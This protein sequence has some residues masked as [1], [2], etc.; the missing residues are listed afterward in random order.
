VESPKPLNIKTYLLK[1]LPMGLITLVLCILSLMKGSVDISIGDLFNS[2]F[3]SDTDPL[4]SKILFEIRLPRVILAV[5]VGGGLGVAGVVFQAVLMNPLAE[6]YILGISSGGAFGAILS[7]FL[8]FSFWL[9]EIAAFSGALFVVVIVFVIGRRYGE[10]E[11]NILLLTGVM[12]SAFFGALILLVISLLNESFR[13]AIF[14]LIGNLSFASKEGVYF[15]FPITLVIT[16]ILSF[17]GHKY[18][19]LALGSEYARHLGISAKFIKNSTY[20]LASLMVGCLVSVSGIIGFVGLII[21]HI[22]RMILGIDNRV[23]IPSSFFMRASFLLIADSLARTIIS[24][25][26]L[27]VGAITAVVGAPIFIYLLRSKSKIWA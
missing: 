26:E 2:L 6:P 24:P 27:P 7:I 13:T 4:I 1:I 10:L 23:L 17:N 8:G 5:S 16:L 15:V 12:V 9:T 18:N 3:N 14:W 21:P 25:A 11:P 20:I 22:G 19:V